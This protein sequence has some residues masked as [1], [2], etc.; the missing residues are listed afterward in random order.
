MVLAACVIAIGGRRQ[1]WTNQGSVSIH[2]DERTNSARLQCVVQDVV[3]LGEMELC[4]WNGRLDV[5]V[6]VIARLPNPFSR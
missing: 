5:E 6:G 3:E 2:G 1:S 4:K